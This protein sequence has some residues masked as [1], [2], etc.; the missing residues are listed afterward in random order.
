VGHAVPV[1]H[2]GDSQPTAGRPPASISAESFQSG[3]VEPTVIKNITLSL[4]S[5]LA[6][7]T[8]D[9]LTKRGRGIQRNVIELAVISI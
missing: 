4:L 3:L 2:P 1:Y 6:F 5:F 8:I 9:C 7:K